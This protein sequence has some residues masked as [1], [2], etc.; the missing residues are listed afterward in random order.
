[1]LRRLL[2][3]TVIVLSALVALALLARAIV[4]R[5][6]PSPDRV[7]T[8]PPVEPTSGGITSVDS[9]GRS[10]GE[11]ATARAPVDPVEPVQPRATLTRQPQPTD[12]VKA[13]DTD[14]GPA[15]PW[16]EPDDDDSCPVSHPIKAKLSSGIYHSPGGLNY[17]RTK[18]D[19]C[20]ADG[21]AAETDGLRPSKR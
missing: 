12:D 16:V 13:A 1:M 2:R 15:Q 6:R 20:Y 3:N 17:E 4:S 8:W 5:F 18:A 10:A 7:T 19:R 14:E 21:E 11:P 9:A